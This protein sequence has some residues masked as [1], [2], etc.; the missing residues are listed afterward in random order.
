MLVLTSSNHR[1]TIVSWLQMPSYLT[2]Y[3]RNLGHLCYQ[4]MLPDIRGLFLCPVF[5]FY[6]S[7]QL[8]DH[9][10]TEYA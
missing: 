10:S 9:I 3:R 4:T 5:C 8:F 7:L 1:V 6:V 2:I